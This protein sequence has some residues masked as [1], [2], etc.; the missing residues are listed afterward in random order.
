MECSKCGTTKDVNFMGM[1]EKCYKQSLGVNTEENKGTD[2]KYSFNEVADK[3]TLVG[4]I[5]KILGY[6]SAIIIGIATIA[7][8]GEFWIGVVS[9][10]IIAIGVFISSLFYDGIA[11]IINLLQDIKDK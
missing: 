5:I 8:G 11:E 1:C 4:T 9:I 3:F 2:Y 10:I 7:Q 6:L